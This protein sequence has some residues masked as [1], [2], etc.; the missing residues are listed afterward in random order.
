MFLLFNALFKH[1]NDKYSY[2]KRQ[3]CRRR[4]YSY[5]QKNSVDIIYFR[6]L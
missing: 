1:M 4:I 6:S 2:K 3:H 5:A